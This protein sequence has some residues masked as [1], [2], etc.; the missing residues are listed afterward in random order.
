MMER[1]WF[2]GLIIFV[3]G[4]MACAVEGLGVNWGTMALHP[5]SPDIVVQML[6]DN[7]IKKVKLFDADGD[8]L[9]AL[10]NTDIEVMVAIPNNMLQHLSDSYKAA[11]K[12][13]D[14]NVTRYNF[15][16][17]VNIKYVAV[18]N[19]PFLSAY[20][21]SYLNNTFP[22]LQNIHKALVKAG[23]A[24]Q[25]KVTV[26]LNAD[27][28]NSPS[29][30]PVPSAGDFRAD[31][32]DL[33]K[34]IVTFLNDNESPFTVNIYPF[35]SLYADENFP[36]DFA[37]FDGDSQPVVDG[38]VQY[39]NVF[40]ANLDTLVWSLRKAGVP[41]MTIIVG[42]VG[43]PTDGDKHATSASAQRFNQ[44]LLKHITSNQGTPMRPGNIEAYL[45]GLLDEDAKSVAPGNF[46]RH[47]GIFGYDGQPKYELDF[48]GPFQNGGLVPAKNVNYLLPK[49]CVFNT[50]ATDQSKL[51]DSITYA[52]TY[53]DCTALGYGSS[54]N[55]LDLYGN[56]SY[57]FNMYFQVMN[58]Y[59]INCD[60][61]GLAVIT[62]QNASQGSCKFPIG[63]AYA[64]A[65]R[66][67]KI[68]ANL[69]AVLL[70]VVTFILSFL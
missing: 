43:W 45:F 61:T 28:Y 24:D 44:G 22:A 60:F 31:I 53:S 17:G 47:W 14:K 34:Q 56:A 48:S 51:L 18:G 30:N 50:N 59:E 37:F 9:R 10:A 13:V 19:E 39:T 54:C 57:A 6:K 55:N 20:N 58:Q 3:L 68:H 46:E 65:E 21:G 67:I 5:L 70:G 25:I 63:I 64:A 32:H 2:A 23:L 27:V 40:D 35:L 69:A 1:A 49:W 26:P 7:G 12:W 36:M 33:M 42:E 4:S 62:E 41:N 38:S 66:S 8:T 11:E 15:S 16:G 29:D 52:C